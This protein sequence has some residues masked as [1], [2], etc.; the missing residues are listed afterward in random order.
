MPKEKTLTLEGHDEQVLILCAVRYAM[1]RHTYMPSLVCD[2][3]RS[4]IDELEP[5]T[6]RMIARD[7]RE[8]WLMWFGPKAS[9]AEALRG[10]AP[11]GCG[12]GC[13]RDL[14]PELDRITHEN[15]RAAQP[16]LPLGCSSWAEVPADIRW[17][18]EAA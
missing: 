1:G 4:H 18:P 10:E 16:E 5:C 3:I 11:C 7:I 6:A 8:E 15:R 14:L 17:I 13:F 12:W 9:R 2:V